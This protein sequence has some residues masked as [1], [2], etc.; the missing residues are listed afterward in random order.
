MLSYMKLDHFEQEA[1]V[2][3]LGLTM[4]TCFPVRQYSNCLILDPA[5]CQALN[6]SV[7]LGH[8]TDFVQVVVIE[9]LSSSSS[10]NRFSLQA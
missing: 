4:N 3:G 6:K 7:F 1:E 9:S 2:I 5:V 10:L 8:K